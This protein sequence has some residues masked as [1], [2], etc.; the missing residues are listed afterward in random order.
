[1]YFLKGE[2]NMDWNTSIISVII[3]IITAYATSKFTYY[4]DNKRD[5]KK[6][7]QKSYVEKPY[8]NVKQKLCS[9]SEIDLNAIV[10][11]FNATLDEKGLVNF[12]YNK[13]ILDNE[14][15][16]TVDYEFENAG[17]N[18]AVDLYV[19]VCEQKYNAIFENNQ[20]AKEG[21]TGYINY[22]L[23]YEKLSIIPNGSKIKF[24]LNY[25]K[26]SEDK[27]YNLCLIY[28]DDYGNVWRQLFIPFRNIIERPHTISHKDK[29]LDISSKAAI[30]CFEHPYLW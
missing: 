24:R 22:A 20:I 19:T 13:D 12:G 9:D 3:A 17:K 21:K 5:N 8:F 14:K 30:D 7:K 28:S 18:N 26:E 2:I 1:M 16:R 27:I 10:T 23:Y 25:P 6:E 11:T 29:M 15:M 4:F